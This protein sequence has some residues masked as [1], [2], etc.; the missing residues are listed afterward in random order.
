MLIR[1][2]AANA[3]FAYQSVLFLQLS[4]IQNPKKQ[5]VKPILKSIISETRLSF[6]TDKNKIELLEVTLKRLKKEGRR[7]QK[8]LSDQ[9]DRLLTTLEI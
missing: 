4:L 5:D 8:V 3:V 1:P 6:A 2:R 9:I 7:Y